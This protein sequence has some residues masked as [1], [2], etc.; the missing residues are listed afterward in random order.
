[1]SSACMSHIKMILF[2]VGLFSKHHQ[3]LMYSLLRKSWRTAI[4]FWVLDIS[5]FPKACEQWLDLINHLIRLNRVLTH[6]VV[7]LTWCNRFVISVALAGFKKDIFSAVVKH[8]SITFTLAFCKLKL[9]T[10]L[11]VIKVYENWNYSRIYTNSNW[12]KI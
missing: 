12:N 7:C 10:N 2:T 3:L 1:M 9:W 8:S 6:K 11:K 5:M 4:R